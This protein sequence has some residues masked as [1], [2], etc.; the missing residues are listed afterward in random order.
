MQVPID[1]LRHKV[2]GLYFFDNDPRIPPPEIL[3]EAYEK[4][5]SQH[6]DFEI[7]IVYQ[8]FDDHNEKSFWQSFKTMPW[9]ALPFKDPMC[10]KLS[11][12]FEYNPLNSPCPDNSLVIIGPYGSYVEPYGIDILERYGIDAYPFTRERA[13]KIESTSLMQ[14]KLDSLFGTEAVF[15]RNDQTKV[16]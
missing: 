10:K 12:I 13:T 2:V 9:L 14:L 16:N 1:T 6:Q 4:L 7:V 15:S 3:M 11:R 8:L 5:K